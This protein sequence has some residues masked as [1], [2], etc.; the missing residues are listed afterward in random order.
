MKKLK[1][2]R[3]DIISLILAAICP[4][5]L[6]IVGVGISIIFLIIYLKSAEKHY[7]LQRLFIFFCFAG[8]IC[9]FGGLFLIETMENKGI[10][11]VGEAFIYG[12]IISLGR[13]LLMACPIII[14]VIDNRKFIFRKKIIS[15]IIILGM[16]I[17]LYFPFSY[18]INTTK[19]SENIPTVGDFE[20]EL[21]QRGF[22]TETANYRLY[23]VNSTN[24]KAVKLSFENN[25]TDKY[26]LY[27]YSVIDF[28]WIIYYAN[29]EIYA[30]RG[31]YWDY[32]TTYNKEYG[33]NE[34][35][36][37]WDYSDEIISEAEKISIYNTQ[38][39]RYEKGNT[40]T[41]T[42]FNYYSQ[43]KDT[44]NSIFINIPC[45]ESWG[46]KIKQ[47]NRID[48]NSLNY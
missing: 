29:E 15:I 13:I 36:I 25:N 7:F 9:T 1:E 21:N 37:I 10:D 23:G 20:K 17:F 19:I 32:Y 40:I 8:I 33:Y 31:K 46:T 6:G 47:I 34:E 22:M 18:L 28:P 26:P 2:I 27:V 14:L 11:S 4:Y 5:F 24:K 3:I 44:E 45:I 39:N 43:N 16:V 41:Y 35:K 38:T 12:A 48:I 42:S 30:V